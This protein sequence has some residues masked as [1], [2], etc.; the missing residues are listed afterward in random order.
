MSQALAFTPGE[1]PARSEPLGR[2]LPPI[3]SGVISAWLNKEIPAGEWVLDPFG[4]APRL[5]V[6]AAQAG[7]R[8]LVAANNPVARFLLEMAAAPPCHDEL[9]ASLAELASARKGDERIEPHIRSL[10]RTQCVRCGQ[11]TTAEVFL[12]EKGA[13]VPFARLYHCPYC[14]DEGERAS[15]RAD[16]ER[17]AQFTSAGPHWA[18]A[19]ERI[20]PL[21]TPDRVHAEEALEAYLP[22]A[23]YA[24][25]TMLNKLDGL[26]LS[27]TQRRCLQALLLGACDRGN[28][29]WAYPTSRER[30]R[31]LLTPARYREHNL[32]LALEKGIEI[33]GQD[34]SRRIAV[35][36][37]IWPEQPPVSGGICV[38]EGR[39]KDLAYSL[40]EF[41]IRAVAA[42]IPR[43]NQAFWTLSALWAGW[44]W[45][46][47]AIGPFKSVLRRRR[48]DWGWHTSALYA[49]FSHLATMLK[50]EIP[51]L[52]LVG[53]VEFGF[54]TATLTAASAAGFELQDIALRSETSQAQILWKNG[55]ESEIGLTAEKAGQKAA[56]EY[57][58]QRGEPA[59]FLP[60]ASAALSGIVRCQGRLFSSADKPHASEEIDDDDPRLSIEAGEASPTNLFIQAQSLVRSALSYRSGYIRFGVGDSGQ[61]EI[62]QS[63]LPGQLETQGEEKS[64]SASETSETGLWW[65]KDCSYTSTPLA[66]R[67]EMAFVPY[68]IRHPGCTLAEIDQALCLQF[69]GLFTPE[70][71]TIQ[72]LLESYAELCPGS[73]LKWQIRPQDQPPARRRDLEE[74][75]KLLHQL[76]QKLGF[77][78]TI[79]ESSSGRSRS[80]IMWSDLSS[81][82][83]YWFYP[84]ASAVVGELILQSKTVPERSLIVLPGG[85]ANLLLYKLRHDPRLARLCEPTPGG[86]RFIKFR[87]LRCLLENPLLRPEN[88]DEL[89]ALDPLTYT[90]SQLRLL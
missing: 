70:L 75:R 53:E 2:Y 67:L 48:Y 19:L 81:Q 62:E 25:F 51:M 41:P 8:L 85:R 72:V 86:W 27:S 84:I 83:Q 74:T 46:R 17:A 23:V 76:G 7:Y 40:S 10:Y 9:R 56:L 69:P 54:L 47:E 38:F 89:F 58:Q 71:E 50:G 55:L 59:A 36:L 33:W 28:T 64:K 77:R 73:S 78:A 3:P 39:L 42:A 80:V 68:L 14:G 29:L 66:D 22:R 90:T 63:A 44:L 43:P 6:E 65:L 15:T 30:P 88:L 20:A 12:W 37:T 34:S 1:K 79:S 5:A 11:E 45:G 13:T 60:M 24:L 82:P 18:R 35:P 32:W 57:L 16:L 31:Q 49:A 52:G 4:A 26:A 21:H 87:H 61:R